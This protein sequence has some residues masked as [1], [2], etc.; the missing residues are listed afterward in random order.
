MPKSTTSNYSTEQ[1]NESFLSD[2][3]SS[4]DLIASHPIL[5]SLSAVRDC[6]LEYSPEDD[7]L[8]SDDDHICSK[9]IHKFVSEGVSDVRTE[10]NSQRSRT[11]LTR[12]YDTRSAAAAA[13]AA[14]DDSSKPSEEEAKRKSDHQCKVM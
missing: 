8:Y 3:S 11:Y 9:N 2:P 14:V 6:V 1:D 10:F 7:F 12:A 4:S 13:P 5:S